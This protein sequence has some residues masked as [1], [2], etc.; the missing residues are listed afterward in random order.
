MELRFSVKRLPGMTIPDNVLLEDMRSTSRILKKR[1]LSLNDYREHG[2]YSDRT[3]LD[4]F[5][6]WNEA[7]SASGLEVG[8]VAKFDDDALFNNILV[9]WQHYGRQPTKR[10]LGKAPSTISE[11]PYARRFGSWWKALEAFVDFANRSDVESVPETKVESKPQRKNRDPSL[12]LR[13]K[14][15][16]RDRFSCV[17]CG[18]SP[19]K[20]P[21]VELHVDHCVPW[22]KSGET[23]VDNLQTLCSK[24][25]IG[26]ADCYP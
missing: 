4:H 3:I 20:D 9:L 8:R 24:C 21:E 2:K 12:R 7:L 14:V 19:A 26:K 13:W 18:A 11:R 6:S 25:N 15:L 16:Q 10:D 17:A 5:G 23:T 22:S 1:T